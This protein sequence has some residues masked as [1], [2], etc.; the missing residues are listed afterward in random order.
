MG[1]ASLGILYELA[2]LLKLQC[3]VSLP[4]R[5]TTP[6]LNKTIILAITLLVSAL[7]AGPLLRSPLLMMIMPGSEW[8]A[9]TE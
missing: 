2:A 9:I 8:R 3:F 5:Q 6:C 7:P 4:A 1:E